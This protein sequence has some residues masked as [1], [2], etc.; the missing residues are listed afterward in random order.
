M[1]EKCEGEKYVEIF[2]FSVFETAMR[3][4]NKTKTL[5]DDS[6]PIKTRKCLTDEVIEQPS[7]S[8]D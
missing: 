3:R 6:T 7:P 8:D 1:R 5:D 2:L 4:E